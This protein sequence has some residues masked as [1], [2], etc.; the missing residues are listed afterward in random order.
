MAKFRK[1][2]EHNG[3]NGDNDPVSEDLRQASN[4]I[5]K[6]EFEKAL[7]VLNRLAAQNPSDPQRLSQIAS[8]AADSQYGL[9][10]YQEAIELYKLASSHLANEKRI[11][12]WIRPALGEVRALLKSIEVDAAYAR[13]QEIWQRTSETQKELEEELATTTE[14]LEEQGSMQIE[15]RPVRPSV[16]LTRLGTVFMDEGYVDTAREFFQQAVL[17]SPRGATRARQGMAKV[18]QANSENAEAEKYAREAL[19]MGKFQA[20]TV[21]CWEQHISARAKQ[22]K[23]L[24]DQELFTSLQ[25]NQSGAVL[26]RSILVIV[27]LLRSYGDPRWKQIAI[28]W[29]TRDEVIDE[30]IEIELAKILLSDEKLIGHDPRLIALAAHRIFRSDKVS[31]KEMVATAKDVTH[32]LLLDSDEPNVRGLAEKAKRRFGAELKGEVLHAIALGAMMAKRH[33]LARELL[34]DRLNVLP[35]GSKQW[36]MDISALARMEEVLENYTEAANHYLD[37]ADTEGIQS[38]FRVQALLKWL[39]YIDTGSNSV[40]IE[41]VSAKLIPIIEGDLDLVVLLN[42]GRHL[43]DTPSLKKLCDQVIAAAATKAQQLFTAATSPED[44]IYVLVRHTR[45]QNSDFRTYEAVTSFWESLPAEKREWLWSEKSEYWEY[46]SLL[47]EAYIKQGKEGIAISLA[48]S[49]IE[50][51]S[52]PANGLIWL[53]TVYSNWQMEKGNYNEAFRH[54]DWLIKELPTHTMAAWPYYWKAVKALASNDLVNAKCNAA[55]LRRCF[56]GKPALSWQWELDS[57]ALFII[58]NCQLPSH[59]F[60]EQYTADYYKQQS[61]QLN[62]DKNKFN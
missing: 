6:Q 23:D 44:A 2:R 60:G 16:V 61:L 28:E 27:K 48:K 1:T 49:V 37:F 5:G 30:I 20:K 7:S 50:S 55:A 62:Y 4:L 36:A 12:Y 56:A 31:P 29:I 26:A 17:L 52:T 8:L 53:G 46:Y 3:P 42:I 14:E 38:D 40:D 59:E 34:L 57:R 25:L 19:L 32:M 41:E 9:A 43:S 39:K 21:C 45:K 47:F 11:Q 58:C 35:R 24:L 33:D 10:R 54:Y 13:A 22:G 18:C 15:A 51:P